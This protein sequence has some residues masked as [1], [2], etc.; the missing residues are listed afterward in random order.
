M[1]AL[2]TRNVILSLAVGVLGGFT[3]LAGCNPL[4]GVIGL[5]ED[6]LFLQLSEPSHAALIVLILIIGGFIG[7]LES[8]GGMKTFARQIAAWVKGPV[9]AQLAVWL[10][11]IGIFFSDSATPLILGPIFRPVLAQVGVSAVLSGGLFGDHASP[12]SDTTILASM[13]AGC[14]HIDHVR[15]Q[16]PYALTSAFISLGAFY[17]ASIWQSPWI[18]VS[19]VMV[20]CVVVFGV[21][22]RFGEPIG[23]RYRS[24]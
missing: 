21:M 15:T 23:G 3:I 5:I 11:G 9:G 10:G 22:Y 19:S 18:M 14:R 20:L 8:S 4:L 7:L 12:I 2:A 16:L 1:L 17:A 13:G 6:G 24:C